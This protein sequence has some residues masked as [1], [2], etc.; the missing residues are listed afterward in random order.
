MGC[1]SGVFLLVGGCPADGFSWGL[2]PQTP[3]VFGTLGG[4]GGILYTMPLIDSTWLDSGGFK[5]VIAH[6]GLDY[7][8]IADIHS[9]RAERQKWAGI[10]RSL[11]ATPKAAM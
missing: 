7:A 10:F 9:V 11:H 3:L 8:P 1:P 5:Y 6:F 4:D 2:G